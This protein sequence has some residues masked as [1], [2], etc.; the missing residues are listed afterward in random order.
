MT[1]D[2][3]AY[4]ACAR[5]FEARPDESLLQAAERAH[6]EGKFPEVAAM[7]LEPQGW[8][9]AEQWAVIN[10][11]AALITETQNIARA[12]RDMRELADLKLPHG[13]DGKRPPTWDSIK[14]DPSTPELEAT[15][16]TVN[17]RRMRGRVYPPPASLLEVHDAWRRD[18]VEEMRAFGERLQEEVNKLLALRCPHCGGPVEVMQVV[19]PPDALSLLPSSGPESCYTLTPVCVARCQARS[20]NEK[21]P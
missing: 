2:Y 9:H 19:A 12:R 7:F 5:A 15:P 8:T 17:G 11:A 16:I 10:A 6:R 20:N 1:I 4:H 18:R 13:W 21:V 3:D 14:L